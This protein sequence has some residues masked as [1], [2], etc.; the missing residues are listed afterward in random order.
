MHLDESPHSTNTSCERM[1]SL[2]EIQL[3]AFPKYRAALLP[4]LIETRLA[5]ENNSDNK[6]N[7]SSANGTFGTLFLGNIARQSYLLLPS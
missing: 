6:N 2:I 7:N 5:A 1:S 3:N 4:V